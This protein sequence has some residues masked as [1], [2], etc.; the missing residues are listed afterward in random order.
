MDQQAA[1]SERELR[2]VTEDMLDSDSKLLSSLQKLGRELE[3][4]DPDDQDR[5]AK[6]RELCAR[7]DVFDVFLGYILRVKCSLKDHV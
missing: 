7:S 2:R 1:D 4:E 3:T 6:L 5:V